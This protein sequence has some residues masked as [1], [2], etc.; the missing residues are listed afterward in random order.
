MVFGDRSGDAVEGSVVFS[1]DFTVRSFSSVRASVPPLMEG[2]YV[3][4]V[5]VHVAR[6][7]DAEI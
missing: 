1:R 2:N 7:V 3:S 5:R 4:T 6:K